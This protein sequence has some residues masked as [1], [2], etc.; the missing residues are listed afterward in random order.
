MGKE[1]KFTPDQQE[2]VDFTA[3]NMLVSA[4]AGSGKTTVMIY[5]IIRLIIDKKIPVSKFL[6]ISFTKASASDMKNKL[7]KE[8][9]KQEPSPFIL[10]QLDDVLTSDVSN[11]HS[12]CARLLKLYFYEVGLD[13]AFVVLDETEVDAL[14]EKALLKLFNQKSQE[15]DKD[16]YDLIEIFSK[17]RNDVGLKETILS[18]Y[19]FLCSIIDREKW[20]ENTVNSLYDENLQTNVAAKL[21]NSHLIA[22]S[23]RMQETIAETIEKCANLDEPK[24]VE[25]LQALDTR[26]KQINPKDNFLNN[27]TRLNNLT[28]MPSIP[29]KTEENALVYESVN[30]LKEDVNARIKKLKEY[31]VSK[32]IDDISD[33]LIKTQSYVHKLYNL[34]KDFETIFKELKIERGGL[35][36]ND[37]EQY[38][39]KVLENPIINEE[40][41]NKYDYVLIDEYQ[42]INGVQEE[43][44]NRVSKEKNRFMVGDVKQSIYRFRL[45]DPE[46]F[47]RKY[48]LYKKDNTVGDLKKLNANFR[49]KSGIIDF[50]NRVFDRTMTEHFGGVNYKAEARLIPGT[51]E[52]KDN[53]KR[54]QIMFADTSAFE[55]KVEEDIGLYSVRE[56]ER[57]KSLDINGS[58]EGILVVKA[59][60]DIM[61]NCKVTD[62]DT[63]K[64]RRVKFSDIT[65]LTGSRNKT[66]A[67]IVET[68]EK[69]GIP[70][71]TDIE[72]DCF[73]DEYVQGLKSF[74]EVISCAK[75]DMSLF[76]CMYSK[77]F[78]FTPT[79]LAKIKIVGG[80]QEKFF[81]SNVFSSNVYNALESELKQKLG[82]FLNLINEYRQKSQFLSVKEI[83]T[84]II[85]KLNIKFKINFEKDYEKRIAKLNKFLISLPEV[86]VYEYLNDLALASVKSEPASGSGCVKVMTIHKSKGLEFKVTILL[87]TAKKFNLESLR[88]DILISKDF[89]IGMDYYNI[90]ERYKCQTLAKQAVKLDETKKLLEEQQRLLYVALTRATDYLYIIGS[91]KYADIKS[92]FPASPMS[93]MDFMGDLVL[94]PY[95]Y[96]DLNY[97]TV[98]VDAKQLIEADTEQEYRQVIISDYSTDEVNSVRQIFDAHYPYSSNINIPLKT[99]VTAFAAKDNDEKSYAVMYDEEIASS[100][101][102][103][104]VNHLVLSM[105]NMEK[106]SP[107]EIQKQISD[108]VNDGVILEEEAQLVDVPGI[109]KLF[110]N[111]EFKSLINGADKVLK[112]KEFFM[113]MDSADFTENA[114]TGDKIVVQGI[115]DLVIIKDNM[116]S[117]VDYKTGLLSA[118]KLKQYKK[119]ISLYASALSKSYKMP[120]NKMYVA[121]VHTGDLVIL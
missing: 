64:L 10:E 15:G 13:P 90:I 14:K 98:V 75:S 100:A 56:D 81:F 116:I 65:I 87:E 18:L 101:K 113:S 25:Y 42:D 107:Q 4:A 9:S 83:I 2:V 82:N 40:I 67:K 45:C 62:N 80:E 70:V 36:F 6:V 112:E 23:L 17:S 110:A 53:Q 20:Y 84:E 86:S 106:S 89:G 31:S 66:L 96:N 59:I 35:D 46:I 27:A 1:I 49:S 97:D 37:L 108:F 50:V 33:N 58:A 39:L 92:K 118:E 30:A 88:N 16:F 32:D 60:S 104:T 29:K 121:S 38:T 119:Q 76:T 71:T 93:F 114:T 105:L 55:K 120:V 91:G 51:E 69:H 78:A 68:M 61:K 117:V 57:E 7:I 85:D 19:D 5:H 41:K 34:T 77:I 73:E 24:F 74:L 79:E 26:V 115:A 28:R 3:N 111:Q 12:F 47:L 11:L 102:T 43:I 94:N 21:I 54:V 95:A 8:L 44:L 52:Q 63:G 22:E 103:G 48:N 72:G 109:S 99:A